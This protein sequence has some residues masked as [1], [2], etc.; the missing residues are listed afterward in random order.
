MRRAVLV[1][2]F[3]SLQIFGTV[4]L[5]EPSC[6]NWMKQSDGTYWRECVD[7][8]GKTYC[9]EK[10]GEKGIAYRVSCTKNLKSAQ[11]H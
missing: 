7:D 1:L 5:S 4:A 2:T 10:K 9:E 11:R 3:I 6:T 8:D